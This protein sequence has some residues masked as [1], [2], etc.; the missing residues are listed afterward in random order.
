MRCEAV[1]PLRLSGANSIGVASGTVPDGKTVVPADPGGIAAISGSEWGEPP[2][3]TLAASAALIEDGF[4]AIEFAGRRSVASVC[5]VEG[6][7]SEAASVVCAPTGR[8]KLRVAEAVRTARKKGEKRIRV[9][10]FDTS[11]HQSIAHRSI[12]EQQTIDLRRAAYPAIRRQ[13]PSS[14][15]KHSNVSQYCPSLPGLTPLLRG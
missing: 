2:A 9:K 1:P 4:A 7:V 5:S 10:E 12:S 8:T 14:V 11:T 6:S 13:K 15:E 3:L